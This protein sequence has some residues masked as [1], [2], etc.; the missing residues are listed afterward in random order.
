MQ[1]VLQTSQHQF[2]HLQKR[3]KMFKKFNR[4][5]NNKKLINDNYE[6]VQTRSIFFPEVL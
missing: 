5:K 6:A 1:N 2:K 3:K 4:Q